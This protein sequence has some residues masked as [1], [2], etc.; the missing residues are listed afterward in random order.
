MLSPSVL[1]HLFPLAFGFICAWFITVELV[2]ILYDLPTE[3]NAQLML[4]RLFTGA[5]KPVSLDRRT[6]AEQ[7]INNELIRTGGP[8]QIIVGESDVV[9]TE[10]NGAL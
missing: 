6:F 8:G 2:Q 1:R 10:I 4:G 9:V 7:R 5:G 3:R